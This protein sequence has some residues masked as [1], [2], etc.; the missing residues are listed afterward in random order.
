MK[1]DRVTVGVP[2]I[3]IID[4]STVCMRDRETVDWSHWFG[5]TA[6]DIRGDY[7]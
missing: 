2:G 7:A 5:I 3:Y 6:N 4:L 1:A